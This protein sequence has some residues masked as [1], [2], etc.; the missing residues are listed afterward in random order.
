MLSFNAKLRL[1]NLDF[2]VSVD[3]GG[4]LK[5]GKGTRYALCVDNGSEEN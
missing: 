2:A 3:K 5:C 1:T 4:T